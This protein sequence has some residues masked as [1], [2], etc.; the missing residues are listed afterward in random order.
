MLREGGGRE[1][2][3]IGMRTMDKGENDGERRWKEEGRKEAEKRPSGTV[4]SKIVP[5]RESLR[6]VD[7]A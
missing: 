2:G 4:T 1:S 6:T 3:A 5:F 7:A